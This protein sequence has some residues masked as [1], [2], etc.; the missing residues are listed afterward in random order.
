MEINISYTS[1]YLDDKYSS[2]LNKNKIYYTSLTL[3]STFEF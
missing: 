1:N 2:R 3:L